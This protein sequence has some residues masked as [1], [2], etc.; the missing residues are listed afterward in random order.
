M[1]RKTEDG[2]RKTVFQLPI[3][4]CQLPI[5]SRQFR[6]PRSPVS[7]GRRLSRETEGSAMLETVIVLPVLMLFMMLAM[8]SCLLANAR[9]LANYAAFCA[10]RTAS[11]Y[12]VDST[13]KTRMAAAIAMSSI[14]PQVPQDAATILQAYGMADPNQ[15]VR[16]ICNIPGFH[17]DTTMWLARLAN[18]Y[19]RTAEPTCDTGTA[20]GKK[21]KYVVVDVTY[22]YHCSV[23]P[24]GNF[25]G[26][27]GFNSYITMLKG[28]SFYSLIAPAVTLLE[29]S[30]RWNV[31]IHGRAVM[32]YW[33]G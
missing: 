10:A 14:S 30:W 13:A 2:R 9:Q 31:P 4:N 1:I 28:L 3:A 33:A 5:V 8:E 26:H 19:L 11:V 20:P 18:A 25:W 21:R 32:D 23:L 27:S 15:T 29:N 12:G 16:T 6:G 22:I 17:G 7:F 24:F